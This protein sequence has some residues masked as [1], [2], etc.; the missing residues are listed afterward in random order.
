MPDLLKFVV[1]QMNSRFLGSTCK[2]LDR[3]QEEETGNH[4]LGCSEIL[5]VQWLVK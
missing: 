4:L 2:E 5:D 3:V 1:Q